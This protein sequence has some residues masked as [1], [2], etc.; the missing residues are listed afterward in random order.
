MRSSTAI[1]NRR[2]SSCRFFFPVS[3]EGF[4]NSFWRVMTGKRGVEEC[5]FVFL[6]FCFS[7]CDSFGVRV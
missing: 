4:G 5:F 3:V 2:S 6:F 7:F 1:Q